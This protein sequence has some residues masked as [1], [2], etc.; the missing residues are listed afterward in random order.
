MDGPISNFPYVSIS[1]HKVVNFR[2]NESLNRYYCKSCVLTS[3]NASYIR[4]YMR[5]AS[6]LSLPASAYFPWC[7]WY[8]IGADGRASVY[9]RNVVHGIRDDEVQDWTDIINIQVNT[10]ALQAS[11]CSRINH[12][13]TKTYIIHSFI[14]LFK[15][16]TYQLVA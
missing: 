6:V 13:E 3:K 15:N 4:T 7:W 5:I 2:G 11:L 1:R 9:N 10:A 12:C 16:L 14:H 8:W